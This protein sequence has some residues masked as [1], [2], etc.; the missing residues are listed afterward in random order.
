[1]AAYHAAAVLLLD[2]YFQSIDDNGA[3]PPLASLLRDL[4]KSSK[5]CML[6]C[7]NGGLHRTSGEQLVDVWGQMGV[8]IPTLYTGAQQ[9]AL[10]GSFRWLSCFFQTVPG[11]Q[12]DTECNA[13][14]MLLSMHLYAVLW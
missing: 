10:A 3:I 8:H 6:H 11:I 13:S 4:L 9:P 1:L 7:S 2:R 14:A 5:F 12:C